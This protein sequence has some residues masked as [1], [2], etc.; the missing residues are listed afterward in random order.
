VSDDREGFLEAWPRVAMFMGGTIAMAGIPLLFSDE[1]PWDAPQAAVAEAT[2]TAAKHQQKAFD[3]TYH[4]VDYEFS[5]GE[6]SFTG[7]YECEEPCVIAKTR[8]GRAIR[9]EY[10]VGDPSTNRPV[11]VMSRRQRTASRVMFAI[12]AILFAAGLIETRRRGAEEA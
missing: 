10:L 12:G 2:I 3:S 9:V 5:L 8:P 4:Q 11:G 6:R 1:K 7:R